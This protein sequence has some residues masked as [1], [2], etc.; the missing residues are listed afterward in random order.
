MGGGAYHLISRQP[1][2][3]LLDAGLGAFAAHGQGLHYQPVLHRQAQLSSRLFGVHPEHTAQIPG[4]RDS[5]SVYASHT[6]SGEYSSLDARV[7]V[8]SL[9][10]Q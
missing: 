6:G 8:L 9:F 4:E 7:C 5:P 10:V 2:A 3:L 1:I